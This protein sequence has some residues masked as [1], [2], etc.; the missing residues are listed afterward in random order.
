MRSTRFLSQLA[1]DNT[2]FSS[3]IKISLVS[4][5]I[6]FQTLSS[7]PPSWYKSLRII[8]LLMKAMLSLKGISEHPTHVLA[9]LRPFGITFIRPKQGLASHTRR[10]IERAWAWFNHQGGR[11]K[12]FRDF[13]ISKSWQRS[14]RALWKLRIEIEPKDSCKE[15]TGWHITSNRTQWGLAWAQYFPRYEG[16][17]CRVKRLRES[18]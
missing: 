11:G 5:E 1:N 13:K 9:R 10:G 17:C 8:L 3:K 14:I 6:L 12:S 2:H 7:L 18:G 4:T 16:W 15:W